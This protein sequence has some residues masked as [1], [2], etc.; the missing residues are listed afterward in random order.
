MFFSFHNHM[1]TIVQSS[2]HSDTCQH[3]L[4]L[5]WFTR[6]LDMCIWITLWN[7]IGLRYRIVPRQLRVFHNYKLF[8]NTLLYR[9]SATESPEARRPAETPLFRLRLG[10][11]F[12]IARVFRYGNRRN[13]RRRRRLWRS[14]RPWS[15]SLLQCLFLRSRQWFRC[16]L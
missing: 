7:S 3:Y 1:H 16:Q 2:F 4:H 13:R 11:I 6:S 8:A 14:S 5:H 15:T 12:E 9:F 10:A